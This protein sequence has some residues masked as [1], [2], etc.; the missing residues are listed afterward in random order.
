MNPGRLESARM[1]ELERFEF[2]VPGY[3]PDTMPLDRLLEYLTQLSI[4]LGQPSELHL[5]AIEPSSTRP[6][7]LA[8]HDVAAKTRQRARQISQGGGSARG[9]EAFDKIRRMVADDGQQPAKLQ[10]HEGVI[11]EFPSADV[12]YDQIVQAVRQPTTIEGQLVRIGGTREYAQLLIQELAGKII[13]GCTATRALAQQ[14]GPL[15]YQWI[16]LSGDGLWHR[17]EEGKWEI[18]HLQIQ[19]FHPLGDDDH[20]DVVAKLRAVRIPW[21]QDASAQLSA[22][23]GVIA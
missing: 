20:E 9:R 8:R 6:V 1:A 2:I 16:S 18:K 15:I 21:P 12:A 10:A 19:T 7:F 17:T 22:M 23:R 14:L 5:V 4:V 13:S 3:T 11:L